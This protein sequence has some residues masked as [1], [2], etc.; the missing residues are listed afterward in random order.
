MRGKWVALLSFLFH[1]QFVKPRSFFRLVIIFLIVG[2]V[3]SAVVFFFAP[4]PPTHVKCKKYG[5]LPKIEA[6]S[7]YTVK[8][9]DSLLSI[10]KNE[11][12]NPSRASE[13]A[14]LN[15][16]AY[17]GLSVSNPFLEVGW[18]LALPPLK[19]VTTG[20]I[21][22]VAG[23]VMIYSGERGWGIYWPKSGIDSLNSNLPKGY[24]N[25]TCVIATYQTVTSMYSAPENQLI[26]IKKQ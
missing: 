19:M 24:K 9:G 1:N 10:A 21:S 17:P 22:A 11:L 6:F 14:R 26:S 15:Q 7:N 2:M 12:G 13:L 23:E 4:P 25:G 3:F 16:D 8:Q 5:I 20:E 18:V